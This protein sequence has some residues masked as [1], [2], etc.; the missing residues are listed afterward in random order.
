MTGEV[1]DICQWWTSLHWASFH[2]S[3]S[4]CTF[5]TTAQMQ[6]PGLMARRLRCMWHRLVEV[7]NS[8][9]FSLNTEQTPLHATSSRGIVQVA[10]F[11]A[12]RG[13]D[14]T[15]RHN[16]ARIYR[17]W[18]GK[19]SS[20]YTRPQ[21]T[22]RRHCIVAQRWIGS[23]HCSGCREGEQIRLTRT[24]FKPYGGTA[25]IQPSGARKFTQRREEKEGRFIASL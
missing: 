15:V 13:A 18:H 17:M 16:E 10:R 6:W 9:F 19:R 12:G 1:L 25:Q 11:L 7:W 22:W 4:S 2:E 8:H 24:P 23:F 20:S 5:S 3:Y 21:R 14:V